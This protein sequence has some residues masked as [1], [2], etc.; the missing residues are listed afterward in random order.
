MS[1]FF[2][3]FW[4][5]HGK[6]LWSARTVTGRLRIGFETAEQLPDFVNALQEFAAL[7]NKDGTQP[8]TVA[9][10]TL[11]SELTVRHLAS[12]SQGDTAVNEVIRRLKAKYD[13]EGIL[14]PLVSF[15]P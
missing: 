7:V 9:Y 14:N 5:Q 4:Q 8:V 6:P 1:Y 15:C 10:P 3:T 13:P 11:D 2:E 12:D